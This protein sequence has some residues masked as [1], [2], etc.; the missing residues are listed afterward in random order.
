[1][2][3]LTHSSWPSYFPSEKATFCCCVLFLPPKQLENVFNH[4]RLDISKT[5]KNWNVTIKCYTN[6]YPI[7]FHGNSVV[8]PD[9]LISV[10]EKKLDRI[11]QQLDAAIKFQVDENCQKYRQNFEVLIFCRRQ[12]L[13]LRKINTGA[14]SILRELLLFFS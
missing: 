10:S 12:E 14:I 7:H 3:W 6:L 8:A 2:S 4:W 9:H 13:V 11:S 5:F 1:M